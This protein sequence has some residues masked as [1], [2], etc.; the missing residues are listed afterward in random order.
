MPIIHASG[1][2]RP[3]AF[4][5][6]TRTET[7]SA[8][9]H[10][11]SWTEPTYEWAADNGSVTATLACKRDASHVQTETAKATSAAT[12]EP[13]GTQ[14]TKGSSATADFTFKRSVDDNV[15][16]SH[17]AGIQVDGKDVDAADYTAEPGSVVVKL[18]PAYLETLAVGE[19]TLTAVFDDAGNVDASFEVLAA[20]AAKGAASKANAAAA[21]TGDATPVALLA[22]LAALSAALIAALRA[23]RTRR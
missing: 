13:N 15:A 14:W 9:G 12:K 19:H 20:P 21:K 7:I 11:H 10:A 1:G 3:A 5:V 22:T 6:Q 17:F 16:F 23:T 18:K 4:T 8:E 2:F